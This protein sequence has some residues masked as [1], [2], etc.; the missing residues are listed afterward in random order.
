M[1]IE[2]LDTL[3]ENLQEG[4][5]KYVK[6]LATSLD[7]SSNLVSDSANNLSKTLQTTNNALTAYLRVFSK[8]VDMS[9]TLGLDRFTEDNTTNINQSSA[10]NRNLAGY[11][12]DDLAHL[13]YIENVDYRSEA[14][15][16]DNYLK[17]NPAFNDR[18]VTYEDMVR[19][20]LLGIY[21]DVDML[22]QEDGED[23]LVSELEKIRRQ[24][25]LVRDYDDEDGWLVEEYA[26]GTTHA[27]GGMSKV[28]EEGPETIVT[29]HGIYIPLKA[30]DGVIPTQ[31]TENLMNMAKGVAPIGTPEFK[32]PNIDINSGS[33]NVNV[34]YDSLI[35][36]E[37]N[38]DQGVVNQLQ[39]IVKGLTNNNDFKQSMYKYTAKQMAKDMRKAGY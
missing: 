21:R 8:D 33:Q 31:M 9:G 26:K 30:G 29:D 7:T 37:G 13:P 34:H 10:T 1:R 23:S 4:Y 2:G 28:F 15:T 12:Y 3:Q 35:N 27:K 16:Y 25:L 24:G 22:V 20:Y 38:V 5:D 18:N 11:S 32:L 6:E 14:P 39:D 19:G 36:I 17:D